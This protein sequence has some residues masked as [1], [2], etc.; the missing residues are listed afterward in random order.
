MKAKENNKRVSKNYERDLE[1]AAPIEEEL[2]S[3]REVASR[4]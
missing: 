4:A 1:N 3:V 2:T